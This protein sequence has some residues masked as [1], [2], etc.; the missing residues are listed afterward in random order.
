MTDFEI[1]AP[2]R[3]CAITGRELQPGDAVVSVLS[4]E[5]GKF[6]RSDFAADAW[7]GPLSV[8]CC[9]YHNVRRSPPG[10]R[11]D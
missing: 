1:A 10:N 3:T 6:V 4:E 9:F 2:A 7:A 5:A 8:I 11:T